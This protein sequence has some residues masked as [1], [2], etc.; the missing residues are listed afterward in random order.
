MKSDL[1]KRAEGFTDIMQKSRELDIEQSA[2]ELAQSI[3]SEFNEPEL[4]ELPEA[5]EKN[6]FLP[7][8]PINSLPVVLAEYLKAVS[9]FV[10][11]APEMGALPML[12]VLSLCLQGKA[13]V[14]YPTNSHNEPLNLYTLTVAPPGERKSGTFKAFMKP[15][16]EYVRSYN[17][18]HAVEIEQNRAE[19]AFLERQKQAAMNGQK[20]NIDKVMEY[21]KQLCELKVL[22]EL[23]LTAADVTPEALAWEMFEQGGRIAVMDDEG[24]VFDT[25]SGMYSKGQANINLLLKAYDGMPHTICRRSSENISLNS[26]L[27]T[28]GILTQPQQFSQAMAN[29]QFSGRGLIQRFLYSFPEGRA[30]Q[31]QYCSEDIPQKVQQAY[32]ELITALLRLPYSNN[33]II[34]DKESYSILQGYFELLQDKMK[35]GGMFEN[36]KEYAS[37]HFGKVLRIAGILH[38]CEHSV[39]EPINGH[40]AMNAISIGL[41]AENMSLK[42]FEGGAFEDEI[43]RNAKYMIHRIKSVDKGLITRRELIHLC[44]GIHDEKVFDETAELLEDMHYIRSLRKETSGRPSDQYHINPFI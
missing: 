28:M 39:D 44:R 36:M 17:D 26:P 24:S 38:L 25:V 27:L 30:G 34:H 8:F 13:V 41:W 12:S 42:A 15:V 4:W 23:R 9:S 5:F 2:Y 6:V 22:H 43:I 33:I 35:S 7:S 19:R 18:I 1:R 32:N 20:A 3:A 40:T 29:P 16:E 14:K 37:K 31:Q 21:T 11:V 10:Q